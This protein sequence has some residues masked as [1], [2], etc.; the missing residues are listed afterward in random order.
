MS[1]KTGTGSVSKS[2]VKHQEPE[3]LYCIAADATSEAVV[4]TPV[5]VVTDRYGFVISNGGTPGAST[6]ASDSSPAMNKEVTRIKKWQKMLGGSCII[7]SHFRSLESHSTEV[8][9]DT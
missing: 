5:K 1:M 4:T 2:I 7:D 8:P 6:S 9:T 3:C